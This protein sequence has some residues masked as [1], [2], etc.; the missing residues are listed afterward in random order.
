MW[1]PD[2]RPPFILLEDLEKGTSSL[3]ERPRH[4]IV[5][6]SLKEVNAALQKADELTDAGETLAGWIG[7]EA[8]YAFEP[9]LHSFLEARSGDSTLLHLFSFDSRTLLTNEALDRWLALNAAGDSELGQLQPAISFDQY[10]KAFQHVMQ[11]IFAGDIYQANLTFPLRGRWRGDPVALYRA[12]RP[13]ANAR[14]AALMFDGEQ[15]LLSFS[16]ELF[17]ALQDREICVRPMKGTRPRGTDPASDHRLEQE[18]AHSAKDRAENLMIVDLM[19]N[20]VSKISLP[21]SVRVDS[22]FR[23]ETY[24]T[25][26]QMTTGISAKLK[27]ALSLTQTMWAMFPCGSITG[28]PKVRAMEIIHEVERWHRGPYCGAIGQMTAHGGV[29]QY[30][31]N[32]AIRTLRLRPYASGVEGDAEF[33]VGSGI[34]ADSI[35]EEEWEECL[36]KSRVIG[37]G[38]ANGLSL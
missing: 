38:L 12:I 36:L 4:E 22:L 15:W 30:R 5:A 1:P 21:G 26:F 31:F 32:V 23:I 34:V 7:Y 18:L 10:A 14:F 37:R 19:R 35:M 13:R 24:P 8:G 11:A 28:A 17:F 20:D 3:L 27:D 29:R 6:R 2:S 33:G 16:P 25:V 9:R